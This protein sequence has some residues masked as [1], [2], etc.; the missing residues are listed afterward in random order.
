[1]DLTPATQAIV[2]QWSAATRDWYDTFDV[3]LEDPAQHRAIRATWLLIA[4]QQASLPWV[5]AAISELT[6]K[7][8]K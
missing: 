2:D 1:M 7:W 3:D 6:P 8:S 4:H 5:L